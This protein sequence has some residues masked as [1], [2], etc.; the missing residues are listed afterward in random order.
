VV[1][2][3]GVKT[4]S[5][6]L[7]G[8][9]PLVI[10]ANT[11]A[12]ILLDQSHLTTAYPELIVSGGKGSSIEV[13]YAEALVD[14]DRKKGNRN[15]TQGKKLF[16]YYDVF[17]PDGGQERL[18]RPLWYRTYRYVELRVKTGDSPLQIN[19]YY[20]MFTAYPFEQ[21]ASFSSNDATLKNIWDVGWRTARLCANE[22]YYDCP[23]YEQLQYV[24]DTRIQALISLYVSGD[25]R[26][27]R[28]ALTLFDQSRLPEGI[29]QSRYP[30][31]IAQM[32]PT[33][34]LFWVDMVH[35]YFRF[36]DDREFVKGFLPGVQSTFG[37]Y[38]KHL[39]DR[40]ILNSM[41]WW[42]FVD[43][44][45]EFSRGVPAGAEEKEGTSIISLQFVYALDR[46]SEIFD[47]Y[48]KKHEASDYRE[49]ADAIRKAVYEHCYDSQKKL[50]ADTPQKKRFS[51]H[52]NVLAI[53][54]DAI[55]PDQ[56][57]D[58]MKRILADE[59]LIQCT[60]YFRFYLM[61]A[62][63]KAGMAD[64]YLDHLGSWK[65]MLAE[66]LTTFPEKES[67]TRSDCHAWSSSPMIEFLATVC[68]IEPSAPGFR[69]VKIEPHL[70]SLTEANGTVPHPLG[71]IQVRLKKNGPGGIIAEIR[72]PE[73][74]TGDFV[75]KNQSVA[76]KSGVQVIRK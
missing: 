10:A 37:W 43:W 36:R 46:A 48:G 72:L 38:E 17:V 64:Q 57:G 69:K 19:D 6:F 63:K 74:V 47:S 12:V 20:G 67:D 13:A 5:R 71:N 3:E 44:A 11:N 33:F 35:D 21:K 7:S 16:G 4:D 73:G 58:L 26:L 42:N 28:N 75:W 61:N 68:G 29:T 24:G 1:R 9:N 59:S 22:T 27:M 54:T 70:G 62:L 60:L 34:S 50:F 18:F 30:T 45:P 76:L 2:A 65:Q 14:K 15:E 8:K 23:Y 49:R 52:A 51:Q 56:Q 40:N 53:L 32:I 31:E 41:G 25:D 39:D 55:P 66:G